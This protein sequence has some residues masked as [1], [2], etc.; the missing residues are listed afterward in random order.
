MGGGRVGR[1]DGGW[2][3][4]IGHRGE[5]DPRAYALHPIINHQFAKHKILPQLPLKLRKAETVLRMNFP[6]SPFLVPGR[7]LGLTTLLSLHLT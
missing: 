5:K 6:F 2:Q 1:K 4:T 3:T 7:R